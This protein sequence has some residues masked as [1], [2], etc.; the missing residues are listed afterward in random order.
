MLFDSW[1]G[2]L[3]AAQAASK[4]P[5]SNIAFT[6]VMYRSMNAVLLT[7]YV[8]VLFYLAR[9]AS[10]PEPVFPEVAYT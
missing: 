1:A 5:A 7:S 4:V 8:N 10:S 2:V 3:T 6:L 9:K